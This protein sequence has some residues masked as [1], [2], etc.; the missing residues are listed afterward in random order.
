MPSQAPP[1]GAATP[2]S[3]TP[4]PNALYN[5][6]APAKINLFLHITGR[7]PDGYHLLQSVFVLLD[8]CDLLHFEPRRDGRIARSDIQ[9]GDLP[10]QDLCVRAAEA[11]RSAT[12]C[13]Q[14]VQITLNKRLP[15]QAGL[16]GGSSDAATCLLALNRLWSLGLSRS[17]LAQIG[18]QLGADVPFFVGGQ[19][20]W[21]EGVGERLQPFALP[22]SAFVLLKP[23]SGASTQAIFQAPG[24]NRSSPLLDPANLRL[25]GSPEG[26]AESALWTQTHNALQAV[27]QELCPEIAQ[28]QAWLSGHGLSPRMTGSGSVVFAPLPAEHP[29]AQAAPP[30]DIENGPPPG[31]RPYFPSAPPVDLPEEGHWQSR[32]CKNLAQHPLNGWI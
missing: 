1:T 30:G 24:L 25:G 15:S 2:A 31:P 10:E 13:T 17:A 20:A 18:L 22:S 11:L 3:P 5:L 21:V 8:W 16:G 12:G 29:W 6:P 19:T 27:A 26:I 28:A 7:R 9:P 4:R 14:G 23:P 32:I